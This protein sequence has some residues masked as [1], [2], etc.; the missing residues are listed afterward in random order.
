MMISDSHQKQVSVM[1]IAKQEK[2]R[3]RCG[4][5]GVDKLFFSSR[6]G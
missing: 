4:D 2:H 3:D 1:R 5:E 6:K